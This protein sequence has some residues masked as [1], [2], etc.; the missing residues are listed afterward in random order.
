MIPPETWK[1]EV[2]EGLNPQSAA[3]ALADRGMLIPGNDTGLSRIEKIQGKS[4]RL[5][6][7]TA[8]ILAGTDN[9]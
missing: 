6:V 8:S 1:T 7:V 3:R 2:A 5:Y 9:E 4:M